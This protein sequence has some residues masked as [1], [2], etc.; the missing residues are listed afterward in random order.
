MSGIG[1]H[2]PTGQTAGLIEPFD[3]LVK[4]DSE[5]YCLIVSHQT[6]SNGE[7]VCCA[8]FLVAYQQWQCWWAMLWWSLLWNKL[9][10]RMWHNDTGSERHLRCQ[11]RRKGSWNTGGFLVSRNQQ[12]DQLPQLNSPDQVTLEPPSM[13]EQSW[14]I[15]VWGKNGVQK[16]Q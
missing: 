12:L 14:I 16:Q 3:C 9:L 7:Q 8:T 1:F 4:N 5:G 11:K 10:L 6:M 13:W 2:H 15:H